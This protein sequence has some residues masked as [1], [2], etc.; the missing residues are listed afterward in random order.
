MNIL[1]MVTLVGCGGVLSVALL[2]WFLA[3]KAAE[4]DNRLEANFTRLLA[5]FCTGVGGGLL[6]LA[7]SLPI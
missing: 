1:Q 5:L 4:I 6:M 2:L 7:F 3:H